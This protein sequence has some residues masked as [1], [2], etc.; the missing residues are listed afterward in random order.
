MQ[1]SSETILAYGFIVKERGELESVTF[2][3]VESII[4]DNTLV[5]NRRFRLIYEYLF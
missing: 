2:D 3:N 1:F 4:H 5:I